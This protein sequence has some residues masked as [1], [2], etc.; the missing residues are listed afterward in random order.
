MG[1][2]GTRGVKK[3]SVPKS[4]KG[5]SAA[6]RQKV[7]KAVRNLSDLFKASTPV[8]K[9]MGGYGT[10]VV[11][12]TVAA[13]HEDASS[14]RGKK[15]QGA[16][17]TPTFKLTDDCTVNVF[18]KSSYPADLKWWGDVLHGVGKKTLKTA[19]GKGAALHVELLQSEN[20]LARV[21]AAQEK[22]RAQVCL[23]FAR[24]GST[25]RDRVLLGTSCARD[26]IMSRMVMTGRAHYPQ[27]KL[28]RG[29]KSLGTAA[30]T[31]DLPISGPK[32]PSPRRVKRVLPSG[33]FQGERIAPRTPP[34]SSR[35][36]RIH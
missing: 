35:N 36:P 1:H 7:E 30:G 34:T 31:H 13:N 23:L 29:A 5:G 12:A 15:Q 2:G 22:K 26:P 16:S 25:A 24:G 11:V 8:G 21:F 9:P 32:T 18:Y 17:R 20:D 33:E 28:T 14:G 4:I 19:T 6:W 3:V 27:V 10:G